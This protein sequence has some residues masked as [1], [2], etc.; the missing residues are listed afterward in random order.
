[1]KVSPLAQG[2]GV[3]AASNTTEGKSASPDRLTRAKALAGG[4]EITQAS[5]DPQVQP[6]QNDIKKIKMK[7][8]RSVYRDN[9]NAPES[10]I[11]DVVEEIKEPLADA[12][13]IDPEIAAKTKLNR[14][15]QQAVQAKETEIAQLKQQLNGPNPKEY[16]RISDLTSN[17]LGVLKEQG[18]AYNSLYNQL[19]ET[20]LSSPENQNPEISQLKAELKALKEGFENQNKT[21]TDRDAQAYKQVLTQLERDTKLLIKGNDDYELVRERGF[22]KEVVRLV[23]Q[24]F[25]K[26]GEV[27]DIEDALKL[28][29]DELLEESLKVARI[30][31]V[32]SRLVPAQQQPQQQNNNPNVRTMRTLTNRD[33][34]SVPSS[35]RERAI[36]AF[37]GRKQ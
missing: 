24:T 33:G 20:I 3:P 16:V 27:L 4:K 14:A 2:T 1:M 12:K 37:Y 28:V 32:Q 26:T 22:E 15:V 7:T 31:K 29:E 19:T 35:A 18:V 13:P 21:Q 36:A 11:Q 5:T 8:Q 30:K 9:Q 17:P 25:N 6:A 10:N 34:A 23:E